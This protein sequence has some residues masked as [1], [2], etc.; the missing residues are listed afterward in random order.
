[1]RVFVTGASGWIG[2]AAVA[3]LVS[4]GHQVLGLARSDESAAAVAALGAEVHR[5]SLDDPA[6]L[7]AAA[8]QCDGVVQLAYNHDFSDMA[9]AAQTDHRAIEAMGEVMR[10]SDKPYVVASGV[11]GLA[12]GRVATEH[13]M[14]DSSVHPRIAGVEYA[15]SLADQGV[16]SASVRFAPTVHG[17]GDHGFVATLVAIARA[18]QVSAY[19]GDGSNRWPAVHRLDAARLV[20]MTLERA[21]AGS[22][23]HAIA[24][25]GVA[26]RDI[27]TAIGAGLGLPVAPIP[28][29]EAVEHFGWL[30]RFFGADVPASSAMTQRMLDWQ[31]T[32]PTLLDDL[33]AGW[34]FQGA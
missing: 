3:E 24:E 1:M 32:N 10:G 29:E 28:L 9:G 15:L 8:A 4:N 12:V 11:M 21:P 25:E 34:Y 33:A 6:S 27:A 16:R 20:R 18:R 2:S 22:S 19:I 26:T 23:V 13:D 31:P 17:P 30:G 7:A 5:G 14:P